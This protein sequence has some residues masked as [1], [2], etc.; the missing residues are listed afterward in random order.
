MCNL[1]S[2]GALSITQKSTG[3]YLYFLSPHVVFLQVFGSQIWT[4]EIAGLNQSFVWV[5]DGARECFLLQVCG[6]SK[7]RFK[8]KFWKES[9]C[10]KNSSAVFMTLILSRGY[11]W[12]SKVLKPAASIPVQSIQIKAIRNK[13]KYL[14]EQ[15]Q[16]RAKLDSLRGPFLCSYGLRQQGDYLFFFLVSIL[17]YK[18]KLIKEQSELLFH[19]K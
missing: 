3:Y 15:D 13:L 5:P 8:F 4:K 12:C 19:K 14:V 2:L 7:C 17:N 1:F 9:I 16:S 10:Q 6:Y 11:S 18:D